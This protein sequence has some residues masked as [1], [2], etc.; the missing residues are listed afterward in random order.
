MAQYLSALG[1][2]PLQIGAVVTGTLI[3]SAALTLGVGLGAGRRQ[4]RHLLLAAA[5]LMAATGV[6]FALASA[7]GLLL[8]VAVVGTLNP[9][10]GDVSVFLPI[11]QAYVAE[12]ISDTTRPRVYGHYTLAGTLGAA[13]GVLASALPGPAS[14]VLHIGVLTAERGGFLL[15]ATIAVG[16]CHA[17]QRLP[18]DD[19]SPARRQRRPLRESR[20]T[21]VELA[22]LFSLDAAGGGFAIQSLLVLWLHLRFGL[23]PT[24]LAVVFFAASILA[25]TSLLAAGP[26][27]QR[28]GL[29]KT[30]VWTHLPA[31]VMLTLAAL[32]PSAWLAVSLL[33]GRAAC[34]SMDVPARQS[35]VMALVPPGERMAAAGVTNVPRALAAA[36]TPIAAGA[37]LTVSHAGW[38][39]LIGGIMKITY[40]L[41]L[42]RLYH[43]VPERSGGRRKVEGHSRTPE[44]G[45]PPLAEGHS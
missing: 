28:L 30:M 15:Y 3:G 17:Y 38:P 21:V 18:Q 14:D 41:A 31:D 37:L 29:V 9:T 35:L 8:A 25:A 42:W 2:S 24:P 20:R 36:A 43:H 12:R 40:D 7:F 1:L 10:S 23:G 44:S 27:A 34:S 6:G 13:L 11:E 22:A 16:L 5:A 4:F 26:L 45:G 39:L 19:R 32:A 33:L